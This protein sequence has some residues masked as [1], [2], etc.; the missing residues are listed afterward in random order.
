MEIRMLRSEEISQALQIAR[1]V[2]D[3]CLKS[4]VN[5]QKMIEEFRNYT[6]ESQIRSME[7][8]G[9]IH[10]WGVFEDQRMLGMSAMQKEGH[11]TMLYVL[12]AFQRKGYGAQLLERMRSYAYQTYGLAYVTVN[13]MPTWTASYFARYKFITMNF[14]QDNMAPY[15]SM[16]AKTIRQPIYE[17]KPISS[18]WVIGTCIAGLVLCTVV[19]V[20]FMICYL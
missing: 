9:D 8:Q 3:Y 5:E 14:V 4:S 17:K 6:E 19:A 7:Q 16:Q 2:F 15:I 11:I 1:G 10:F 18:G 13:A 20:G 12:P